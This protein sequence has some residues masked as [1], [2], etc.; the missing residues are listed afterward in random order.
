MK[1]EIDINSNKLRA[2][3]QEKGVK[4]IDLA[5]KV[6]VTKYTVSRWCARDG[7]ACIRVSNARDIASALGYP[8]EY[9]I[10]KCGIDKSSNMKLINASTMTEAEA[11][12]LNAFRQLSP[13]NQAKVRV[14]LE[15]LI[16]E[17][18]QG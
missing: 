12:W 13:L 14:K 4:Q 17:F 3:L 16:N 18:N 7:I 2:I 10:A 8:Y 5:R 9:F 15:E 6:G 1:N 11:D